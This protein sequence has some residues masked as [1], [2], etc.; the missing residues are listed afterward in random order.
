[1]TNHLSARVGYTYTHIDATPT[2][3]A[4]VDGYVPKHAVN[5][6]LDYNDAKWDAHLDIRGN[7]DSP[8]TGA[9]AFPK[10]T[11]WITDLS[12]NYRVN[13]NITVFGRVNNLFNTY[14]AEQ[15]NVRYGNPGDW[16][17]G[18]GRNFRVGMEVTF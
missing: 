9:N 2:R 14:Y 15:S 4:N 13:D 17:T 3:R 8:G 16:W 18:Q 12:A 5:A 10:S 6:G 7:I 11:Y 1:M